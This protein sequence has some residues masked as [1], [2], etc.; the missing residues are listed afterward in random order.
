MA[1]HLPR[2]RGMSQQAM[3]AGL[4]FQDDFPSPRGDEGDITHELERVAQALLGVK[5]NSR[6][7]QGFTFPEG[8]RKLPAKAQAVRGA[9]AVL[10]FA[11]AQGGNCLA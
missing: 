3:Q 9:P 2:S 4:D 8:L 10:I 1:N 6:A 7:F 11:P 5:Q